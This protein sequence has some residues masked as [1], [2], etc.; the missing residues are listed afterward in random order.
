MLRDLPKRVFFIVLHVI[1]PGLL[2]LKRYHVQLDVNRRFLHFPVVVLPR[3][4][5]LFFDHL[6]RF[7]LIANFYL[8]ILAGL[9]FCFLLLLA[10][11][12]T[13]DEHKLHSLLSLILREG[14]GFGD[15]QL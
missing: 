7:Q 2:L 14:L 4:C 3:Y 12:K 13:S 5:F 10:I 1:S 15:D 11:M 8:L 6:V 9:V